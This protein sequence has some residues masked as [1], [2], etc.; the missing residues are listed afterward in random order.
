MT[1]KSTIPGPAIDCANSDG[2]SP[3]RLSQ[4]R[5]DSN[6]SSTRNSNDSRQSSHKG[7]RSVVKNLT[8]STQSD[9]FR[10]ASTA[11]MKKSHLKIS[12]PLSVKSLSSSRKSRKPRRVDADS[13]GSISSNICSEKPSLR[14]K[15][16]EKSLRKARMRGRSPIIRPAGTSP[17]MIGMFPERKKEKN[18]G[19]SNRRVKNAK[20][21]K[22][23][24][25][26]KVM[27]ERK[28]DFVI[29][30]TVESIREMP[31]WSGLR[32]QIKFSLGPV[33]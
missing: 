8:L 33:R 15:L 30:R 6:P 19:I 10:F 5:P 16:T 9:E 11:N 27:K 22:L 13:N 21:R 18:D 24:L 12:R 7:C 1:T 14:Q 20:A 25:E 28:T 17:P 32:K 3:D 4:C 2:S 23:L 31:Q 29:G 26:S